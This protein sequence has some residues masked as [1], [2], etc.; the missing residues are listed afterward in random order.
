MYVAA[1]LNNN[2][3]N[4]IEA[5]INKNME[6]QSNN[7]IQENEKNQNRYKTNEIKSLNIENELKINESNLN[8]NNHI[9]KTNVDSFKK[10]KN[11]RNNLNKKRNIDKYSN[12]TTQSD[13]VKPSF[14]KISDTQIQ[15]PSCIRSIEFHAFDSFILLKE[16][17]FCAWNNL[18]VPYDQSISQIFP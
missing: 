4:D 14:I 2:I 1:F 12:F 10:S 18:I 7:F 15:I 17:L 6:N 3:Y 16:I 11:N 8:E 5:D 9:I 13:E